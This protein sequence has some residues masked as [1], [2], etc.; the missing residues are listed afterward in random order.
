MKLPQGL[1]FPL[2]GEVRYMKLATG[3]NKPLTV[4]S[5]DSDGRLVRFLAEEITKSPD[6]AFYSVNV[7]AGTD[8]QVGDLTVP[9]GIAIGGVTAKLNFRVGEPQPV[10]RRVYGVVD[11]Q[12]N[13][14]SGS[15][16][17][18]QKVGTGTFEITFT[19]PFRS[20]PAVVGNIW[21]GEQHRLEQRGQCRHR[22]HRCHRQE[23]SEDHDGRQAGRNVRPPLHLHRGGGVRPAAVIPLPPE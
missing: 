5:R 2:T 21:G 13:V 1:A 19:V 12:G 6:G 16:F 7:Q 4:V 23:Q 15:G 8:A 22:C 10:E 11:A 17:T 18:A 14:K 3:I 20:L 9:D